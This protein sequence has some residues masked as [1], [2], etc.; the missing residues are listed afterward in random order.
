[1]GRLDGI[2]ERTLSK[3]CQGHSQTKS[4][5]EEDASLTAKLLF[6]YML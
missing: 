3:Q 6:G 5:A 1:M 4:D 2:P